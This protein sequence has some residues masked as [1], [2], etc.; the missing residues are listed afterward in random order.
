MHVSLL[1]WFALCLLLASTLTGASIQTYTSQ[2]AWQSASNAAGYTNHTLIDFEG[3]GSGLYSSLTLPVTGDQV[4]FYPYNF[5]GSNFQV[6]A[7]SPYGQ[8]VAGPNNDGASAIIALMPS[9]GVNALGFWYKLTTNSS[10]DK[11]VIEVKSGTTTVYSNSDV[12]A[13]ST[14]AFFGILADV[15]LSRVTISH[16]ASSARPQINDFQFATG[17][18]AP[19]PPPPPPPDPEPGAVPEPATGALYLGVGLAALV[20]AKLKRKI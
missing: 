20:T 8:I 2:S 17:A 7:V 18:A 11:S 12:L 16:T 14:M 1:R 4:T 15:N 10:T 6:A 19:P 13:S 3:L 5:T 9:A